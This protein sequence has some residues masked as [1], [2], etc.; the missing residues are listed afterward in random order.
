M[1]NIRGLDLIN[2]GFEENIVTPEE[3]GCNKEF[4]FYTFDIGDNCLFISDASDENDGNYTISFFEFEKNIAIT[5]L[6][7]LKELLLIIKRNIREG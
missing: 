2:L 6:N 1:K 4:T 5:N 3:S 7:E